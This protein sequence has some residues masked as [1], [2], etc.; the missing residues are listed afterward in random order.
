MNNNNNYQMR[1]EKGVRWVY[2]WLLWAP[3][4]TVPWMV[5]NK[6]NLGY[7]AGTASWTWAVLLPASIHI[8]LIIPARSENLYVKR[9]AQQAL[10]LVLLRAFSTLVIVGYSAGGGALLWVLV[11][12]FL[13]IWGSRW[14]KKQVDNGDSWLMR[15]NVEEDLLPR[16]WSVTVKDEVIAPIREEKLQPSPARIKASID[17][18]NL[19]PAALPVRNALENAHRHISNIE[20]EKAV[21]ELMYV[22]RAGPEDWR[23]L[24][25]QMLKTLG[26]LET[27]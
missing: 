10:L 11:N 5:I 3:F 14:G 4:I 13:W 24:A 22:F 12:G 18:A 8:V 2:N 16:S 1:K 26:Q 17:A 6:L 23:K 20:S 15:F 19:S 9:H 21:P 25:I 27:F 7:G